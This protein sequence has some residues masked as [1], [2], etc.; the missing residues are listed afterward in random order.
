MLTAQDRSIT[1]TGCLQAPVA[2]SRP[3]TP[4]CNATMRAAM[5]SFKHPRFFDPLD[6]ETIERVYESAWAQLEAREPFRDKELDDAKQEALRKHVFNVAGSHRVEFDVLYE[7]VMVSI[8][9]PW[10]AFDLAPARRQRRSR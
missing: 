2:E 9:E 1:G 3:R 7:Q 6:L 4:A 8:P 5:G 10:I